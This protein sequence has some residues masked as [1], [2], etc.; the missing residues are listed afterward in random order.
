MVEFKLPIIFIGG[1]GGS[2][3]R[4]VANAM[5]S[6]GYYAG[7]CINNANDN[8]IFTE[9]FKRPNWIRRGVAPQKIHQRLALFEQ[10]M[11]EGVSLM[12]IARWPALG[13]FWHRQRKGFDRFKDPVAWMTKEPNCHLFLEQIL[14]HWPKALFIYVTRHPLDMAYSNNKAQLGN[15]GWL[16]DID[17]DTYA[18]PE[19]AQLD[20]WI[21]TQKR[22]NN[23]TARYK[24]RIYNLKFDTFAVNPMKDM[25]SLAEKLNTSIDKATLVKATSK[26]TAPETIARWRKHDLSIFTPAQIDFCRTTGWPVD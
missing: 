12:S 7:D 16:F 3:T 25:I 24:M 23:M 14:D 10:V 11:R 17:L 22:L 18:T 9:L 15:W 20:Y 2:G 4:A 6:L 13:R 5:I 8:L 1:I 21:R 26:I 19:T